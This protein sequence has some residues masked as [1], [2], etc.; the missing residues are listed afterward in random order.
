MQMKPKNP[1]NLAYQLMKCLLK[2]DL[3]KAS[4]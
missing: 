2:I 4:D 1:E 3:I